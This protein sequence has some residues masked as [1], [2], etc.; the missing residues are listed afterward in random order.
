MKV[1][2]DIP[3]EI[4]RERNLVPFAISVESGSRRQGGV[5][6]LVKSNTT[7]TGDQSLSI[8]VVEPYKP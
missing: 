7:S 2:L 5:Q 8:E 3:D 6:G 1:L 4:I